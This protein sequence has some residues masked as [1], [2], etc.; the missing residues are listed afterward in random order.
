M[1]LNST[2]WAW[3][4]SEASALASGYKVDKSEI[5]EG[6]FQKWADLSF[7]IAKAQVYPGVTVNEKL[8]DAYVAQ[9]ADT[10]KTQIMYGGYRLSKLMQ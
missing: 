6:D 5:Y 3:Y 9:A 1:P 2:D 8:S 7:E 4:T 10:L